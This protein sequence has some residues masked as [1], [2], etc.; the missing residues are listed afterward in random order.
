[1]R[2]LRLMELLACH[3]V[4]LMKVNYDTRIEIGAVV[5]ENLYDRY[6]EMLAIWVVSFCC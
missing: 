4:A 5:V 2:Q 1:M 6:V 3:N